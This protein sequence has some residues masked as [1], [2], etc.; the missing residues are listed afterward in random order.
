MSLLCCSLNDDICFRK[1]N[2]VIKQGLSRERLPEIVKE[3]IE[4][5][6]RSIMSAFTGKFYTYKKWVNRIGSVEVGLHLVFFIRNVCS[7]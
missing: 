5:F 4:Y 1:H 7:G 2:G 3:E 6:E